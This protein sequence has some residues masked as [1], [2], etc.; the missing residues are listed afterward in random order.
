MAMYKSTQTH[1]KFKWRFFSCQ[2]SRYFTVEARSEQE[3]R[4]MLPDAPCLFSA[5]LRQ[6]LQNTA[7]VSA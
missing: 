7:G 2:Q 3:A 1:P 4:S 6:S 5:R